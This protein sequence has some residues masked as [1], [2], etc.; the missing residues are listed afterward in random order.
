MDDVHTVSLTPEEYD[1]V[2]AQIAAAEAPAVR[3]FGTDTGPVHAIYVE[4]LGQAWCG[5]RSQYRHRTTTGT[6]ADVTCPTCL[7]AI[8]RGRPYARRA[9]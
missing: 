1:A 4:A 3:V 8:G 2:Q 5:T 6:N 7:R 9:R